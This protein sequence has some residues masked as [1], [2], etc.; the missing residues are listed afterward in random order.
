MTTTTAGGRWY[1]Q[2]IVWLGAV[3]FF[4]SLA[5]CISMIVLGA[6]YGDESLPVNSE[7][8]LKMPATRSADRAR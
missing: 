1:R 4:A 5:G 8:L 3:I 2:P 7:Q 6:R